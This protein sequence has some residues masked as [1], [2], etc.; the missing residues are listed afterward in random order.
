MQL[1]NKAE[2]TVREWFLQVKEKYANDSIFDAFD[3]K[4]LSARTCNINPQDITLK[5]QEAMKDGGE[6]QSY[7]GNFGL[8]HVS[9]M[10]NPENLNTSAARQKY[11]IAGLAST[12]VPSDLFMREFEAD[13]RVV[14][15][16]TLPDGG[17]NTLFKKY[18]SK[19]F[20]KE[21]NISEDLVLEIKQHFTRVSYWLSSDIGTVYRKNEETGKCK[22]TPKYSTNQTLAREDRSNYQTFRY[23]GRC[24][25]YNE[26]VVKYR[27]LSKYCF[28]AFSPKGL[29]ETIKLELEFPEGTNY[30]ILRKQQK[31]EQRGEYSLDGDS[32]MH[33]LSPEE[34]LAVRNAKN[35][36]DIKPLLETMLKASALRPFSNNSIQSE[37]LK[38]TNEAHEPESRLEAHEPKSRLK[39]VKSG[40]CSIL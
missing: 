32:L 25:D 17:D 11:G 27:D 16:A 3:A 2:Q 40:F 5:K 36:E 6:F 26:A 29:Y 19:E 39:A 24:G 30:A 37:S 15:L 33:V 1:P 8:K 28:L 10:F 18:T 35:F 31:Y 12:V 22:T 21:N 13:N 38:P 4:R 14:L 34:V 9:Q 7:E 23:G 20:I